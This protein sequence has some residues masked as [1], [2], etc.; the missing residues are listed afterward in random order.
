MEKEGAI[1]D[2]SA[3][4]TTDLAFWNGL[5]EFGVMAL[6]GAGDARIGDPD[7]LFALALFA[8]GDVRDMAVYTEY[9]N[10]MR[11]FVVIVRPEIERQVSDFDRG[12]ILYEKICLEFYR[13]R[14]I[15]DEL[16]GYDFNE[17]RLSA[18]F[19]SRKFNCVSSSLLYIICAR[20]FG[21][22][23]KEVNIPSH[24]FVQLETREGRR[25]EIETTSRNGYDLKH[26]KESFDKQKQSWFKAR[27]LPMPSF[28][29]YKKRQ[30]REPFFAIVQNMSN[31]HTA[32]GRMAECDRNRLSEA[33]GYCCPDIRGFEYNRLIAYNNEV[34]YL[35]KSGDSA[36][37]RRFFAKVMPIVVNIRQSA[38]GDTVFLD[39][40]SVIELEYGYAL[41]KQNDRDRAIETIY[42]VVNQVDPGMQNYILITNNASV[43]VQEI[44]QKG[45]KENNYE[46]SIALADRF[47]MF[48][49]LKDHMRN[50]KYYAFGVWATSFW[51]KSDWKNTVEKLRNALDNTDNEENR[52]MV[53]RNIQGALY[54]HALECF[55]AGKMDEAS[56]LLE[57]CRAEFGLESD[58]NRLLEKIKAGKK[59]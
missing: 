52:K 36:T 55:N 25:V 35:H 57:Q 42:N 48:R 29:D 28:D 46:A 27:G 59:N 21:M 56:S 13:H 6:K 11:E 17:S 31:Q 32:P 20:Y 54:N 1:Y 43:I 47:S 5:T 30:T 18:L 16:K 39:L 4:G 3:F 40:I 33:M 19:R 26:D 8:S 51:R 41:F 23:V 10:R 14:T 45:L 7:A 12:R 44:I 2:R 50:M 38:P 34:L 53:V 49:E 24:V 22:K 9:Q 15:N 37:A 58:G